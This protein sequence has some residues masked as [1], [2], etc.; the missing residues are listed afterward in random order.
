[1]GWQDRSGEGRAPEEGGR[2]GARG[3]PRRRGGRAR[4]ALAR[5][6][7]LSRGGVAMSIV[8]PPRG[9][10]GTELPKPVRTLMRVMQGPFHLAFQRFGDRMRIQGRPL[11]MLETVG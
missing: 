4:V 9:T 11:V 1:M 7:T 2:D 3:T 8:V 6:A 10:R 5:R